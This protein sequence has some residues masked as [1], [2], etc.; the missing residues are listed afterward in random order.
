MALAPKISIITSTYNRANYFLPRC[1]ESVFD[2]TFDN[3]E[4]IIID[5]ASSDDT[6]QVVKDFQQHSSRLKYFQLKENSGSDPKPKNFGISKA[7]GKYILH[8][9]D[10]VVLRPQALEKL[11]NKIREGFDVVYGDMWIDTLGEKGIAHDF[12]LQLLSLRNYIDTS[13]ALI[14][15]KAL[16]YVGGWDE[17]LEK[18]VDWNLF[19][20]LAKA[21]YSFKRLP[22]LTFD[23]SLH[24]NTKSQ[25][26]K[27]KT[28]I[29]PQLGR[30]FKPTFDPVGCKIRLKEHKPPKVAVFTIHYNREDYSKE[31]Y[32]QMRETAGYDFDWFS[33][34][35]GDEM[36]EWVKKESEVFID[37][38]ENV[39]I[40][41]ASN[42]LLDVILKND[43]YDIIIKI[44]NDVEFITYN[45]LIDFIDLWERNHLL[46]ASPYV[47][48]L[49]DNPGGA[50]RLGRA[51]IA[52]TLVEITRH[53]GGIFTFASSKGYRGL[54]FKDKHL[55]GMQDVEASEH[56]KKKG[57]MPCYIPKHIIQHKDTTSGQHKKYKNYFQERK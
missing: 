2:Q 12:D 5:D 20:R 17:S 54:K 26:V 38:K 7:R 1:I 19:V 16:E 39:G 31:T 27:T 29:H 8:L 35:N 37:Y 24:E 13:S 44:D 33:A 23:Y 52:D 6:K 46:Y 14:R 9:D 50:P 18:F 11:F 42:D 10:D 57:Y 55:H 45:W 4:H 48:G 30:L 43:K 32:S 51:F 47:E 53:I 28:Y 3:Y 34:N 36:G 15:K 25:K 49:L 22:E 40:S 41:K 21:G 56:F